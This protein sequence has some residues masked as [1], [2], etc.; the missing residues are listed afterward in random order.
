MFCTRTDQI[1]F[2]LAL[3]P[4]MGQV[5]T[6]FTM[7]TALA[8]AMVVVTPLSTELQ[9]SNGN[10]I[11]VRDTD[12]SAAHLWTREPIRLTARSDDPTGTPGQPLWVHSLAG[13]EA[14]HLAA[15]ASSEGENR[16]QFRSIHARSPVRKL[17]RH[18]F[19]ECFACVN[20][21]TKSGREFRGPVASA[22]SRVG[23]ADPEVVRAREDANRQKGREPTGL[24]D[25]GHP[26]ASAR[27]EPGFED[28]R[29]AA[30]A[31]PQGSMEEERR[32]ARDRS[33]GH[34]P[35]AL[36]KINESG[37][38]EGRSTS[39]ARSQAPSLA[40]AGRVRTSAAQSQAEKRP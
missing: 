5:R 20:P 14:R 28:M 13:N 15:R 17:F 31:R 27:S 40:E 1:S 39:L 4:T 12:M 26:K 32:A 23:N 21:T 8:A 2:Q 37:P 35:A 34:K 30:S 18:Y 3:F 24:A 7:L 6:T 25:D 29:P 33:I 38:R 10:K 11:A 22:E 9:H 36:T 19:G 16:S